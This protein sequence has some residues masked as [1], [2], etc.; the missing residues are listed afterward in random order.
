MKSYIVVLSPRAQKQVRKLSHTVQQALADAIRTLA[1]NPRPPGVVKLKARSPA[2]WRIRVGRYRVI[3]EIED[4]KLI[5][6]VLE[7]VDRKDAY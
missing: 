2:Q 5:V 4:D 1:N 6:L 3:Y 7:V